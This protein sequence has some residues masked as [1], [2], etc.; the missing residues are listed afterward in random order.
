VTPSAHCQDDRFAT[1]LAAAT[2]WVAEHDG[3]IAAGKRSD[4]Q[5]MPD[6]SVHRL[7]LWTGNTRQRAAKLTDEQRPALD[8]LGM[9][10]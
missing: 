7:G 5:P 8:A 9:R 6:G 3:T 1:G 4:V 2:A 10:W